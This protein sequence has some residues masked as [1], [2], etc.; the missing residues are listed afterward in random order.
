M[1]NKIN[2]ALI[3][4]GEHAIRNIIPALEKSLNFNIV[5][6][7]IRSKKKYNYEN[8]HQYKLYNS[9]IEA[10]ED[11]NVECIY[12]SSPNCFHFKY[13]NE[14]LN[15]DKHVICEKPLVTD[16]SDF[17]NLIKKSLNVGKCIFESFMFEHHLQYKALRK[18]LEKEDIGKILSLSARFGYPHLNRNNIRY[19]KSLN[20]GS[21]F[22][23]ACYLI[24]FT[25]LILGDHVENINTAETTNNNYEVDT[26]GAC[27][28][29]Y[30][31]GETVFLDWGIGRSYSNEIDIW[32]ENYR[33]KANRFF[34][35]NLTVKTKLILS[36]SRGDEQVI[37]IEPMDHF[38]AMFDEYYK[39]I[40]NQE[41]YNYYLKNLSK[42]QNLY[43]SIH[44]SFNRSKV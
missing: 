28:I 5:G 24:K 39:A 13:S 19:S 36:N 14:A 26:S 30:K 7:Y 17:S 4:A 10:F 3:F 22:D 29:S 6:L 15:H 33:I 34:S 21:F 9:H 32:T 41:I 42:Y 25:T 18:V 23:I 35:K 44:S 11:T 27:M 1:S 38:E 20:G 37:E 16:I 8:F 12:I 43:F 2:I 31:T 40:S